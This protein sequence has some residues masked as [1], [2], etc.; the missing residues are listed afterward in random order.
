[1]H[2]DHSQMEIKTFAIFSNI[3]V[4][5]TVIAR[6]EVLIKNEAYDQMA[7]CLSHVRT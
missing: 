7:F 3:L 2:K 5:I 1:M 4:V 6:G